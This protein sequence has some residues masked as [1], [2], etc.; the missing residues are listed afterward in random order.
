MYS[1]VIQQNIER[2]FYVCSADEIYK[3]IESHWD[4]VRIKSIDIYYSTASTNQPTDLD[5]NG[6]AA[7]N[8]MTANIITELKSIRVGSRQLT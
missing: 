3:I 4:Q 1:K 8:Y 6:V 5:S 7:P 2:E